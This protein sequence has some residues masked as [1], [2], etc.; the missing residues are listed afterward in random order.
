MRSKVNVNNSS[1]SLKKRPKKKTNR[2]TLKPFLR[3]TEKTKQVQ[4]EKIETPI[5]CSSEKEKVLKTNKI[6][7]KSIPTVV[8]NLPGFVNAT[9][10]EKKVR[11]EIQRRKETHEQTNQVNKKNKEQRRKEQIV[12]L[13]KKLLGKNK[14]VLYVFIETEKSFANKIKG[15]LKEK[16][17][18]LLLYCFVRSYFENNLVSFLV[19]LEG[20]YRAVEKTEKVLLKNLEKNETS[21]K[22]AELACEHF[23]GIAYKTLTVY[24][25]S[26]FDSL[27]KQYNSLFK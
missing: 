14:R 1:N 18:K 27:V 24:E 13:E 3:P 15:I 26:E 20:G 9:E 12:K 7:L 22:L 16:A 19:D 23:R 17:S 6:K 11:A 25:K 8:N 5:T 4:P 10:F 21:K 2:K